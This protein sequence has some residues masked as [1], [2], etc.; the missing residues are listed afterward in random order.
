MEDATEPTN[1]ATIAN[2]HHH[3]PEFVVDA[4]GLQNSSPAVKSAI[5]FVLKGYDATEESRAEAIDT[6]LRDMH[7]VC[8]PIVEHSE[9][10]LCYPGV[11]EVETILIAAICANEFAEWRWPEDGLWYEDAYR[12]YGDMALLEN[13]IEVK[14]QQS[15]LSLTEGLR[16]DARFLYLTLLYASWES[17]KAH[18]EDEAFDHEEA[19]AFAHQMAYEAPSE[20]LDGNT[21]LVHELHD[22]RRTILKKM[23]EMPSAPPSPQGA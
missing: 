5:R 13:R 20:L 12:L 22:L 18:L 4:L 21:E 10:F 2:F 23:E 9:E 3:T 8:T 7:L 16:P 11:H 19:Q 17:F 15:D 6:M 14:K 1:M